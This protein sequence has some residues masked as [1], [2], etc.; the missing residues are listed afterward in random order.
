MVLIIRKLISLLVCAAFLTALHPAAH[1]REF[2]AIAAKSAV[3]MNTDGRILYGVNENEPLPMASTTKLMTALIAVERC[4]LD[5]T[6]E[7]RAD[8]CGLEGSSMYCKPGDRY[9]VRQLLCG[10]LL[11]SGNDAAMSLA[12]HAAGS[13]TLFVDWMNDRARKLG[14]TSTHFANPHG[15]SAPGHCAS[16]ADLGLLMAAFQREDAL[17]QIAGTRSTVIGEQTLVNHNKLLTRCPGCLAGKTGYTEEAGRCLVSCC[18]RDGTRLL[19]VTLCDS[20]DWDDHCALYDWAFS[21]FSLRDLT[22][23]LCYSV[24]VVSGDRT[25]VTVRAEPLS[26][27]LPRDVEI[28]AAAELP[29]FVFAPVSEGETAGVVRFLLGG[30]LVGESRLYYTETVQTESRE[31]IWRR[32]A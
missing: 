30:E 28:S 14:M 1:A 7:I 24:P 12:V 17:M 13:E 32:R 26:V 15:L 3:V 19:C 31:P 5:E 2:P 16:A 11:V 20:E 9:T 6:V 25:I 21:R 4:D 23:T 27:F 8:C 29:R 10:L 18:E 22:G